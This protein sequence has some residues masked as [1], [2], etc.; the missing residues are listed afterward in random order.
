[1][2]INKLNEPLEWCLGQHHGPHGRR[3]LSVQFLQLFCYPIVWVHKFQTQKDQEAAFCGSWVSVSYN[4]VS[5]QMYALHTVLHWPDFGLT[6]VWCWKIDDDRTADRVCQLS[7]ESGV[8]GMGSLGVR[9]WGWRM[10]DQPRWRSVR[11]TMPCWH[12]WKICVS[13]ISKMQSLESRTSLFAWWWLPYDPIPSDPI[14]S[15]CGAE[16]TVNCP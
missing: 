5:M 12:W 3:G 8:R 9:D 13:Q 2:P 16:K 15:V 4:F 11:Q 1:M 10:E 14:W 6:L 7:Q